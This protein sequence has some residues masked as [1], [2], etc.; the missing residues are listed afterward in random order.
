MAS[1]SAPSSE[2]SQDVSSPAAAFCHSPRNR[3]RT[4]ASNPASF[5]YQRAGPA[6]RQ[7]ARISSGV[8]SRASVMNGLAQAA[9]SGGRGLLF[10]PQLAAQDLSDIGLW[11][12]GPELDLLGDLVGGELRAAELDHVLGGKTRVLPD[13]EGLDGLARPRI[14]DA[15]HG[16]FKHAGMAGDHFLDLVGIDV[17]AGDQDHV[18]LAIDDLGIA[19]RGHNADIAGAEVTVRRHY[20]GGLVRPIPVAGHHLRALG[21]DFAGLTERHLVAVVVADRQISRWDG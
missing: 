15:D 20:L 19:V 4:T 10:I 6:S 9:H 8:T 16:A 13:D 17:E 11:Q 12:A 18:L 2:V 5:L 3:L 1:A 7:N 14:V 21:A